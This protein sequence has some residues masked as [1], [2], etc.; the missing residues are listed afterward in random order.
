MKLLA[1]LLLILPGCSTLGLPTPWPTVDDATEIADEKA[2]ERSQELADALAEKGSDL[3]GYEP[4]PAYRA[5]QAEGT[6]FGAYLE[7]VLTALLGSAG[8]LGYRA[9]DHRRKRR[10]KPATT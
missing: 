9:L 3:S 7:I 2:L 5:P 10:T 1:L 6:D 8:A 4:T